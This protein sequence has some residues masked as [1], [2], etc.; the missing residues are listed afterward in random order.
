MEHGVLGLTGDVITAG[1]ALA[2]L[3]LVYLGAL[4]PDTPLLRE[5]SR[6]PLER[7]FSAERGSASLESCLPLLLQEQPSLGN[8]CRMFASL[9]AA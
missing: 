6:V 4:P 9:A 1:A 2:G 3:I 7:R 8:G 5:H